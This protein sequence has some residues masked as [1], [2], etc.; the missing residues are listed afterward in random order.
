[1]ARDPPELS[2]GRPP[3][4]KGRHYPADPPTV[5]EIIAVMHAAGDGADAVRLRGLIILLWRAGLRIS[6]G[7]ASNENDLDL[8]ARRD[9]GPP[10]QRRQATRGWNGPV[11]VGAAHRMAAIASQAP[12][13]CVVLRDA[14]PNR[15]SSLGCRRRPLPTAPRG[16]SG[17]GTAPVCPPPAT[18][19][20]RRRNVAGGGAT[21]R[22]PAPARPCGSRD[23]LRLSTRDRQHRDRPRRARA[24]RAD[25]PSHPR[26]LARRSIWWAVAG[27]QIPSAGPFVAQT[28]LTIGTS[29]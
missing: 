27:H 25:N 22:H 20:T 2:Q 26:P 16:C 24:P 9:S 29:P 3:R 13:R 18:T 23:H 14:R 1:M 7:L 11:G 19:R 12:N 4:N 10:R 28:P 6:E 15:R 21:A 17:R 5:E 8:Q